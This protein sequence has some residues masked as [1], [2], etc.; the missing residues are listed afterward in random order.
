[1]DD[2]LKEFV[3]IIVAKLR[4]EGLPE[5]AQEDGSDIINELR[6]DFAECKE[7][8]ETSH[9]MT[10]FKACVHQQMEDAEDRI[11]DFENSLEFSSSNSLSLCSVLIP[12]I[13]ICKLF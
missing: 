13:I 1:M 9:S 5:Y 2:Y 4:V 6:D 12:A 11:W 10:E 7:H 3:S 8:L